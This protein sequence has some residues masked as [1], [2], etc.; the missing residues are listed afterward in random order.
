MYFLVEQFRYPVE[1]LEDIFGECLGEFNQDWLKTFAGD[2]VSYIISEDK[3]YVKFDYVGYCYFSFKEQSGCIFF[4]PKVV[5]KGDD[6]TD[7]MQNEGKSAPTARI[8]GLY[9]P[10]E[11]IESSKLKEKNY[12]HYSF[13][14]KLSYEVCKA[15][16]V[17]WEHNKDKSSLP[18]KQ[19]VSDI[20]AHLNERPQS[21]IDLLR[22]LKQFA[23]DNQD[24]FLFMTQQS[25]NPQKKINWRKTIQNTQPIFQDGVPVYLNP[26]TVKKEIDFDEEL[27]TIFNSILLY[28]NREYGLHCPVNEGYDLIVG[29]VL[30]NY[31]Q[32]YGHLRLSEIRYRYFSDKTL[33]LWHLCDEFFLH[34]NA[35]EKELNKE[36]ILAKGFHNVFEKM[37]DHLIGADTDKKLESQKKLNDGKVIDHLYRDASLINP[38][39]EIIYIADSKYY[40]I[41]AEI[42]EESRW[43]QF[44]YASDIQNERIQEDWVFDRFTHGYDIIPNYLISAALP[45][46]NV[47]DFD[48]EKITEN[49]IASKD[50]HMTHVDNALFS[51]TSKYI[52]RFDMNF[53]YAISLYARDDDFEIY[54]FKNRVHAEVRSKIMDEYD[55]AFRFFWIAE[56]YLPKNT[57]VR[58][59][60]VMD[61]HNGGYLPNIG[62]VFSFDSNGKRVFVFALQRD[63]TETIAIISILEQ[64]GYLHKTEDGRYEEEYL[65]SEDKPILSIEAN[66]GH[67]AFTRFYGA[68]YAS[69][70]AISWKKADLFDMPLTEEELAIFTRSYG[71]D[72][73]CRYFPTFFDGHYY[74]LR[75]GFWCIRFDYVKEED[76]LYHMENLAVS[77]HCTDF[78]KDILADVFYGGYYTPRMQDNE[79]YR[80]RWHNV[81]LRG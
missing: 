48:Y 25:H 42:G 79:D 71:P 58:D 39:Q 55:N 9:D 54:G 20:S 32:G 40:T 2:K 29:D 67:G 24:W 59:L 74:I 5:M 19:F 36:Y 1:A 78:Y 33:E 22:A 81:L 4:M 27:L 15:V 38:Q 8:L 14:L 21:L 12:E 23:I 64:N 47:T 18:Q 28:I 10:V 35:S 66:R 44:T 46:D 70:D 77:D 16:R 69:P 3:K 68:E 60:L 80:R 61:M 45:K 41:G 26:I 31:L 43:K 62:K 49:P 50:N 56:D 51:A 30:D 76:G 73:D 11:Y 57:D 52:F 13:L 34:H 6:E 37:M 75:S 63:A 72:F 7:A 17:Y 53:L 65:L